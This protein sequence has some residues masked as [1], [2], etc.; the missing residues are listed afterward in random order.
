M[1]SQ[2]IPENLKQSFQVLQEIQS[3][4]SERLEE[5]TDAKEE[6]KNEDLLDIISYLTLC[7]EFFLSCHQDLKQIAQQQKYLKTQNDNKNLIGDLSTKFQE[8]KDSIQNRFDEMGEEYLVLSENTLGDAQDL[9]AKY[10]EAITKEKNLP[11]LDEEVHQDLDK[12]L[13]LQELKDSLETY[14]EASEN[15]ISEVEMPNLQKLP[16]YE[17]PEDLGEEKPEIDAI[18]SQ[19]DTAI[20]ACDSSILNSEIDE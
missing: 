18:L 14:R 10:A 17:I 19:I 15:F 13:F 20:A 11:T 6:T 8:L 9:I 4:W 12:E 3:N 2:S 1:P 16:E 5:L 7:D